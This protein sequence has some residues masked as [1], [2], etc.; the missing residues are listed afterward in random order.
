MSKDPITPQTSVT[1]LAGAKINPLLIVHG[2]RSDGYHELTSLMLGLDLQD[3]VTVR[4]SETGGF[5]VEST[6]PHATPDIS[7]DETNLAARGAQVAL[8]AL[9]ES[10]DLAIELHKAIPSRAGLGGGS[11]DAAGAALAVLELLRPGWDS[12][13]YSELE[14]RVVEGL[15]EL[16]ADCA[17]FF[18]AR[19]HGAAVITGRGE[20]VTPQ[21]WLSP[22]HIVLVTP[23]IECPTPAVYGALALPLIAGPAEGITHQRSRNS[24]TQAHKLL[25]AS[26]SEASRLVRNELQTPALG[27]FPELEK[28]R[29]LFQNL[30][31]EHFTL[32]G[33][34]S[35]FFGLF[36][37]A[38]GAQTALEQVTEL[39]R[40]RDLG[41]RYSGVVRPAKDR[42][43]YVE[44][45]PRP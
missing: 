42:L 38:A 18:A 8:D 10:A 3:R 6:G 35:S 34:G 12:G 25:L 13:D 29:I 22:W 39:A 24:M 32:A 45:S 1:V 44:G 4:R 2:R 14:A 17:F 43:L 7:T 11:S 40:E 33:S 36:E 27:T 31:L 28:W 20:R 23:S 15:G 5:S 9:G 30:E 37:D 26:A 41:V 19:S 21:V 16:G